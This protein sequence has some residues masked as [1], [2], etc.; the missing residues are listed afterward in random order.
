MH[1][2][3]ASLTHLISVYHAFNLIFENYLFIYYVKSYQKPFVLDNVMYL[4][5][6]FSNSIHNII[7]DVYNAITL[8]IEY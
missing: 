4:H 8:N 3:W 7:F 1:K 5:K 6:I 2:C